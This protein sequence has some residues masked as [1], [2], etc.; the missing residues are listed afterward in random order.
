MAPGINE[1]M[2]IMDYVITRIRRKHADGSA[3]WDVRV[4]D[5]NNEV[6]LQCT[7]AKACVRLCD[8]LQTNA[9][10]VIDTGETVTEPY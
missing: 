2:G 7:T 1:G 8:A 3:N 10:N 9:L 5:G 6:T 4:S